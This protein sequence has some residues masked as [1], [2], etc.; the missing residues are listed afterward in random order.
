MVVQEGFE[1]RDGSVYGGSVRG[2]KVSRVMLLLIVNFLYPPTFLLIVL[3]FLVF[4]RG[5]RPPNAKM[6]NS[7]T[8]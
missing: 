3:L 8:N 6:R 1:D 4:V 2:L 7:K 5:H